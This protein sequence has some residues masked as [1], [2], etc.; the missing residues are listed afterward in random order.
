ASASEE[1]TVIG[2]TSAAFTAASTPCSSSS[3]NAARSSADSTPASRD[4]ASSSRL[5]GTSTCAAATA[6]AYPR[7]VSSARALAERRI[8][9]RGD[10]GG[11]AARAGAGPARRGQGQPGHLLA[12]GL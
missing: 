10:R 5:S 6:A 11:R 1:T 9:T 12:E 2:P 7:D 4:F 8:R 3:I